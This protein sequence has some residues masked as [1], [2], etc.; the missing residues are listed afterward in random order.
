MIEF[1]IWRTLR[2]V[3]H[4]GHKLAYRARK[5]R[6]HRYLPGTLLP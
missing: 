1:C 5:V 3:E 4:L 6:E 2:Y